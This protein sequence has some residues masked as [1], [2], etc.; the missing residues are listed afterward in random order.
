M[1]RIENKD[2]LK[3]RK[4]GIILSL[5][6]VATFQLACDKLKDKNNK[7]WS[8]N[9]MVVTIDPSQEIQTIHSFGAS[10]CW[11][12][13]YIGKWLDDKKKNYIA[14]LLF[15]LDTLED[16]SPKGIGLSLW[17]FNIGGGSFEQGVSSNITDE[18]RREEC[19]LN[20]KGEYDWSKQQGQ[21]WF[22]QAA[23]ARGVKKTVGFSLTPPVFMTKNGKAYNGSEQPYLNILP[24][25]INDYADFLANVTQHFGFD[26]LSPINEPQWK[27]GTA[28]GAN[29]EGSQASNA[30][31]ASLVNALNTRL[32]G[33]PSKI[34]IAEAGQWNYLYEKN[35]DGRGNQVHEFFSP[36]SSIYVGNLNHVAPV[37]T[38]HSYFTTCP[39]RDMIE[40]R[41][42]LQ[43]AVKKVNPSLQLWQT[44]FG[45]LGN[46][47]N[48]FNGSPRNIEI[49]YGLYVAKVLHHDLAVANVNSWQW[50]L[51]VSPYNYSDALIYVNAIS[52]EI[53]PG[54]CKED[55]Q[56]LTSKQLWVLGNFSRFIRPGM[57]RISTHV[58]S[59][60]AT[61]FWVSA[62]K[63][64]DDKKIVLVI[65]NAQQ[66]QHTL[67]LQGLQDK[68]QV[69]TTDNIH[70]L[71][72]SEGTAHSI[73]VP[74]MAV[75]TVVGSY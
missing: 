34:I 36:S 52:G 4:I 47:C 65:I 22:L 53:N 63:N 73:N 58:V 50:W 1:K 61:G 25:K 43:S 11:T 67:H 26:Y 29:Q 71:K 44:E 10:D 45:I 23:K 42:N 49:D 62:Y 3:L 37:I 64:T 57:K 7:G 70:N 66:K 39:D 72:K 51:A 18:W 14:D 54:A 17:R 31:I 48:Q 28:N 12:T 69:Y 74:P 60:P 19:F 6:V 13:K 15:S 24:D 5:T 46:I 68:V 33:S 55:G 56:V 2:K 59:Q 21:Q 27:W 32:Q 8:D 41:N 75:L 40:V 30:E 38:G 16:G 9:E 20:E 35:D